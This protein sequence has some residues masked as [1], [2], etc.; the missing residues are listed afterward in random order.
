MHTILIA[1]LVGALAA[2]L[3][4]LLGVGGGILM[5]PAFKGFLGLSMKQA[6]ATSLA[7]MVVT[8]S[9]S[10]FRYAS[11]G[12]ID[13]KIAGAAALAALVSAYFGSEL[14]KSL[15]ASQLRILFGVFLIMVG[16]YMLFFQKEV[17]S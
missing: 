13:W 2:L 7:I 12:L 10:S 8:A 11:A 15:S 17:T 4:S 1:F 5:V 16:V 6:I 9:V 14:M 3:G